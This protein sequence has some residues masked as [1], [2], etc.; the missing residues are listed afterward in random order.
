MLK[1][2]ELIG[3]KSF[4]DKTRFEFPPGIT[5]IVGPNGSG[6][7]NIVD[8][9]KW[10]LGEQSARSLRGKEMGDVIFKGTGEGTRRVINA[11]EAT[12]VFDN[13]D[14]LLP[15]D[16][17]E[18]HVTRRVY[19]SGEGEYLINREPCRLRDIRNLFRGT[20]VGADAY[21]LIEQG[22]VEQMLQATPRERRAI[23][24]EAA[25]ISRFKAKKLEALRR[26]ERVEQNLLRLRDIV[27]EVEGRLRSLRAQA[28][29]ARRYREYCDRLQQLRTQVG[30]TD[31]RGL[32]RQ[33]EAVEGKLARLREETAQRSAMAEAI[34]ARALE[35]DADL[36][37]AGQA[38]G[39]C[40]S[41]ASQHREQIAARE[42][43]LEQARTHWRE[44]LDT[45]SRCRQ[46]LAAMAGRAAEQQQRLQETRDQLQRSEANHEAIRRAAEAEEQALNELGDRL[47][48]L[49]KAIQVHRDAHVGCMHSAA[50]LGNRISS[51]ESQCDGWRVSIERA[52]RRLQEIERSEEECRRQLATAR[53]QEEESAARLD[54]ASRAADAAKQQSS[55]M[56]RDQADGRERLAALQQQRVAAGARIHVL[57]ELDRS[58][59][60]LDAGVREVLERA[61]EATDGPFAEVLGLVADRIQVSV[62]VAP[63]VDVVLGEKA[64]YVVVAGDRLFQEL[65][66]GRY[67]PAGRVG[68]IRTHD[69]R[70]EPE[71][72]G[73]P[74]HPGLLGR[75]DRFVVAEER[76][77]GLV[78][79]LLGESWCVD[80]LA[81]A[82]ELHQAA[83]GAWRL[84]ALSGE[85]VEPDGTLL[86]GSRLPPTGL[87]SRRSELRVLR[88]QASQLEQSIR[89]LQAELHGLD[90]SLQEHDELL[91]R[92]EADRQQLDE[93]LAEHR[94]QHQA[95]AAQ[96][97]Q[98]E[99]QAAALRA[100]MQTAEA[101]QARAQADL[102]AARGER[103]ALDAQIAE[104]EGAMR[105]IDLQIKETG[106]QR[107]EHS[108][109]AIAAKVA[110]AKSEQQLESLRTRLLQ[111]EEGQRERSRTLAETRTQL[112]QCLNRIEQTEREMLQGS[113]ELA[114][115]YLRKEELASQMQQLIRQQAAVS[116]ERS[117]CARQTPAL[118]R[119]IRR[120]EE[121]QHELDLEAGRI[122][123]QRTALADRLRED[124]DINIAEREEEATP[125][126]LAER[127]EVEREI[128]DLRSK[129]NNIGAVNLEALEELDALE[130][131][132]SGLSSQYQDLTQAKDSLERI[133]RRIDADSRR[134]FHETL[135]AI[136]ANFQSLYRKAFGGGRADLV[137]EADV[138][139]LEAGIDIVATPPGKPSFSNSL[140]SGGEKALTA[141]ALLLAVFQYRPSPFCVLDEVDAPFDEATIGRF[142]DV[143]KGFLGWTRFVLVT[144]SKKT[145][146]AATTL[147]GI[148]MQESGVSKRVSVRFDDVT[149]D[150]H[151]RVEGVSSPAEGQQADRG[152]A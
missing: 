57:E 116:T 135:D 145:M 95:R 127:Q 40:E 70:G 49:Q 114:E 33:L 100:E 129:I 73:P 34:E 20:G 42:S 122:R 35:L 81:S 117:R 45:A 53:T 125:Q 32:T 22:K 7:S 140:L 151:I 64:Q 82:L 18:V 75:L 97:E 65:E 110:V 51:L 47:E 39:A 89:D 30:L 86:V 25:G 6:K 115:L 79:R 41:R 131:R 58:R 55:R 108:Q 90:T 24:E 48:R 121:R 137:L 21:S 29:K 99:R 94:L 111:L 136:R 113:T 12:I 54:A 2:L 44:L 128:S 3:F 91:A 98:W 17:P 37:A 23:F 77:A 142:I 107:E 143:L 14:R 26:L 103:T 11:A 8:A 61:Q 149:E 93:L 10:V 144:H 50:A 106:A 31:W 88:E 78:R 72:T 148:T 130:K 63:L 126:E 104:T 80:S 66:A 5:V 71:I 13:T 16:A 84:V 105:D 139:P 76:L 92:L 15:L 38:I 83:P 118:R 28:S 96:L 43:S 123:Q 152:A 62:D 9:I 85:M 69:P 133:I 150:G 102:E 87:V 52:R 124:Y 146:T 60:G 4:A 27:E 59:D 109:R 132:F 68:F 119:E 67:R 138:D 36:Q 101:E 56:R 112:A 46:Q 1:A 74:P 134:L 147:Y 141:V 120:L 19:R